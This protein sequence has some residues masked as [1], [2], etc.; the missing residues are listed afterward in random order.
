MPYCPECG[1]EVGTS[2]RFCQECGS[3]L[4][5]TGGPM[6]G[7]PH[8]AGRY[9]TGQGPDE[10]RGRS[11]QPRRTGRGGD[12]YQAGRGEQGREADWGEQNRRTGRSA[13]PDQQYGEP[14][15]R[16]RGVERRRAGQPG[17]EGLLSF[18]L[19][20]PSR[21][22]IGPP[23]IGGVVFFFFWLVIPIFLG[24]GYFLRLAASAAAGRPEPPEFDDWGG[25][26][27]DGLVFVVASLPVW[28]V[29]GLA[30]F[31]A[32]E[33]HAALYLGVL[34][35]GAY[36]FPAIFVN[37]AVERRWRA[38]YD[39]STLA[40]LMTTSEYV[41]GFLI[42]TVLINGI[43]F[44]VVLVLMIA[45]ALPFV[46]LLLWPLIY[47]Y[48]YSIDA[49]LWGRVYR[50]V[51]GPATIPDPPAHEPRQRQRGRPA[52]PRPPRQPPQY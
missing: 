21:S 42:Y 24:V 35:V 18:S 51:M 46:G 5:Q 14:G 32:L 6:G 40:D 45:T 44:V 17:D 13:P 43:G 50:Q 22:G 33:V 4:E 52:R 47:F 16:Q 25:M 30:V 37:F 23:L 10:Q 2:D 7:R 11:Q 28:A 31:V 41:V 15:R 36:L 8:G 3:R 48:W 12:T 27:K 29:Y 38:I 39:I 9:G 1:N 19:S 49:A 20:Y 26:L 34:L